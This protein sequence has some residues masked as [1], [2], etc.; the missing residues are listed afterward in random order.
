MD[1]TDFDALQ[2]SGD[3][4]RCHKLIS[5]SLHRGSLDCGGWV[6][7]IYLEHYLLLEDDAS[8]YGLTDDEIQ[9]AL[10]SHLATSLPLMGGCP[11][12]LFFIG[13]ITWIAEW[14]FGLEEF[15]LPTT[16]RLPYQLELR[17]VEMCPNNRVFAWGLAVSRGQTPA[18]GRLARKIVND[19]AYIDWLH[20]WGYPG[21]YIYGIIASNAKESR[22][23]H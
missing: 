16:D 11:E 6:R 13:K 12:Y 19:P 7:L 23:P 15:R 5:D 9:P 1:W 18:A 17:A 21:D 8:N 4:G 20:E 10:I 3:L 14:L 22:G 2:R